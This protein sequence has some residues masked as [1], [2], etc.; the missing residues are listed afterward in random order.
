MHDYI[1]F[2][3][4]VLN[5]TFRVHAR[6]LSRYV[7]TAWKCIKWVIE[8]CRERECHWMLGSASSSLFGLVDDTVRWLAVQKTVQLWTMSAFKPLLKRYRMTFHENTETFLTPP[9]RQSLTSSEL[10][11]R[12]SDFKVYRCENI[13]MSF[14]IPLCMC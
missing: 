1:G 4:R 13:M 14:P 9:C 8:K 11:S 6:I 12:H 2:K 7:L 5:K 3:M 10:V